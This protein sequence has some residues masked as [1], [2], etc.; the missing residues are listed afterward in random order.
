MDQA[1]IVD[2]H[3]AI[4]QAVSG[5]LRH[6][7]GFRLVMEADNA[8]DA[9]QI[10]CKR[11]PR[12]VILELALPGASGVELIQ[13]V[14]GR[15]P[16]LRL[17]VLSGTDIQFAPVRALRAGAHGFVAKQAGVE[18]LLHAARGVM[19]GYLYFP[20]HT[21]KAARQL[22]RSAGGPAGCLSGREL[23][24]LQY[25]ARGHPNKSIAAALHISAK[26]VSTHKANLMGKLQIGSLVELADFARRHKLV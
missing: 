23:S 6:A 11:E 2:D 4:R 20:V 8:H 22:A 16:T 12:L 10:V 14:A 9:L 5:Q 25:L 18:D 13:R 21:L 17:L 7:L 24:V 26:T 1:L 3:P 19:S 15:F